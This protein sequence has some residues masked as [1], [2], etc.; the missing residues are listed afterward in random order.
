MQ[1]V[2]LLFVQQ[3]FAPYGYSAFSDRDELRDTLY[4][5]DNE[6]GRRPDIERTYGPIEDWDVSNVISFRWLFSGLRWFNEEVGGWETSQVTDMSYTFQDASAF[7]KDI[8][9]W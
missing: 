8:G 9:S 3:F 2:I 4:E 6:A 7:N 5:W 1:L